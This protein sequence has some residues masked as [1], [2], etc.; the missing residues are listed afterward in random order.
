MVWST[1]PVQ[2]CLWCRKVG[3]RTWDEKEHGWIHKYCAADRKRFHAA[4]PPK[5]IA[6]ADKESG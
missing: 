1:G 3:A 6:A 2:R 5:P 4:R